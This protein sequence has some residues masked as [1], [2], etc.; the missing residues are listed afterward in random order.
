ML[1]HCFS[2][3]FLSLA[4]FSAAAQNVPPVETGQFRSPDLVELIKLDPKFKLDIR[5]AS[6][7]NFVGHAVYKEAKAF[8]QRSAAEA[9]IRAH[10]KANRHGYGFIIFDAYRPWSVTKLF[11]DRFPQDRAYLA[12][13]AKGSRHNRGCAVDVS[14]YDLRTGQAVSMPS[15]FDDFTEKAH[16]DYKGGTAAQRKAR[17]QLRFWMESE[18]F[19]VYENEWWHFDCKEWREYPILNIPFR[20]IH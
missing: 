14:L 18:G 5:Y 3:L 13:P 6:K 11:W 20:D 17:D 4:F 8:L 15:Q 2:V 7:N 9:L 1:K 19:T 10:R 12:D 16:P